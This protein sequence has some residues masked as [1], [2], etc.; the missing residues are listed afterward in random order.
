MTRHVMLFSAGI[1]NT[2]CHDGN[3]IEHVALSKFRKRFMNSL[4]VYSPY[5]KHDV[6]IRTQS[7]LTFFILRC[8]K[9]DAH[10]A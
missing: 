6:L 7:V 10:M 3:F 2:L 9:S 1:T 8:L 4:L 5:Y